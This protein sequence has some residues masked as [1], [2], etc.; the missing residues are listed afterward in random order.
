M[1][2]F[3]LQIQPKIIYADSIGLRDQ[4]LRAGCQRVRRFIVFSIT[5][6]HMKLTLEKTNKFTY[7]EA[8]GG[9][10]CLAKVDNKKFV[11]TRTAEEPQ[12]NSMRKAGQN[13]RRSA[14]GSSE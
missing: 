4:R 9:E 5:C 13:S 2:A 14:S 7:S 3:T 1:K 6:A 10:A 12:K 8:F 11:H